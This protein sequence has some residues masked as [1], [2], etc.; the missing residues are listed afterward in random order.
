ML[1]RRWHS[2]K[3]SLKNEG[4][5]IWIGPECEGG[6]LEELLHTALYNFEEDE[7]Q[8]TLKLVPKSSKLGEWHFQ[9]GNVELFR[10]WKDR[11]EKVNLS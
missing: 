9:F 4:Q 10:E 2:R 3:C 5:I 1:N 8:N 6:G 11:L 7:A